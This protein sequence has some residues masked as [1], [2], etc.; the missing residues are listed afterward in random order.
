MELDGLSINT[1]PLGEAAQ[2]DM[3][4]ISWVVQSAMLKSEMIVATNADA[5][6][7]VLLSLDQNHGWLLYLNILWYHIPHKECQSKLDEMKAQFTNLYVKNLDQEMQAELEQLF[8]PF[9]TVMSALISVNEQ[10]KN[11]GFGFVKYER[12]EEAQ[13][14]VDMLH[15][16]EHYG[17][18]I[19]IAWAQKMAA[20]EEELCH[21]Y[22]QAKMEKL[23]T[24]V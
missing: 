19:F 6:K 8:P 11:K 17:C 20:C 15:D 16:S 22:E 2:T 18:K 3:A 1:S 9:S 21:S 14:A 12:H 13:R 4:Y 5:V 23:R 7:V 24:M 10:G